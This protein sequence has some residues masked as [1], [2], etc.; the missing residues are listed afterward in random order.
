MA[1]GLAGVAALLFLVAA[2]LGPSRSSTTPTFNDDSPKCMHDASETAVVCCKALLAE[3]KDAAGDKEEWA[4]DGAHGDAVPEFFGSGLPVGGQIVGSPLTKLQL[5][6]DRNRMMHRLAA[7]YFEFQNF[8]LLFV[9]SISVTMISG[10]LANL[11]DGGLPLSDSF[12]TLSCTSV[13][14]LSLFSVFLQ[15][16]SKE[17]DYSHRAKEHGGVALELRV[18]YD[19]MKFEELDA[20]VRSPTAGATIQAETFRS[21]EEEYAQIVAGCQSPLLPEIY[22]AYELASSRMELAIFPPVRQLFPEDDE[23]SKTKIDWISS[24]GIVN[25]EVFNAFGSYWLWPWRLPKAEPIVDT[26]LANIHRLL[27]TNQDHLDPTGTQTIYGLLL[28]QQRGI[29]LENMRLKEQD[30]L[31]QHECDSKVEV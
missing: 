1:R 28:E 10:V 13:G 27:R 18:L 3:P 19:K 11:L 7:Q 21:Y 16:V 17:L 6:L 9:P 24:M 22:N 4:D 25:N 31:R 8:W 30:A 26:A 14:I 2:S 29:K 23:L 5:D 12:R 20:T 15:A